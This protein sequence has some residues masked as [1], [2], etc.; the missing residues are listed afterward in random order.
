VALV[1]IQPVGVG[2]VSWSIVVVWFR[3]R[4]SCGAATYGTPAIDGSIPA[5]S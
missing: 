1:T 4:N 3:S 5:C 2:C